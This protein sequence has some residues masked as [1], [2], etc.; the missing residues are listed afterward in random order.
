M[1][2]GERE[3]ALAG[4]VRPERS[5]SAVHKDRLPPGRLG[6]VTSEQA[7][8]P[9]GDSAA[10][11]PGLP[12]RR[13]SLPR[14]EP[15]SLPSSSSSSFPLPARCPP[16]P[17]DTGARGIKSTFNSKSI[18]LINSDSVNCNYSASIHPAAC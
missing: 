2:E 1:R 17:V 15:G 8:G 10:I 3:G 4:R 13:W 9:G 12:A 7:A 18:I 6:S 16:R 14:Y 5:R 11:S